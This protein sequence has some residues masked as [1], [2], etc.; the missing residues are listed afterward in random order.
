MVS[1]KVRGKINGDT[2]LRFIVHVKT[3]GDVLGMVR[4]Y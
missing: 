1:E 3:F 2:N 4:D